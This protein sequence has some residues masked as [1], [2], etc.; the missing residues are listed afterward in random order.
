MLQADHDE[1]MV[2]QA[3]NIPKDAEGKTN[4]FPT[5][6]V[7]FPVCDSETATRLKAAFDYLI[8]KS[9]GTKEPF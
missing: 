6:G 3:L 9:G 4:T 7:M 2:R 5:N 8:V 1:G